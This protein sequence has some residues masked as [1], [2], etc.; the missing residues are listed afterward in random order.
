LSRLCD[1]LPVLSAGFHDL[2][3]ERLDQSFADHPPIGFIYV[4]CQFSLHTVVDRQVKH[5]ADDES[6]DAWPIQH[7]SRP[8]FL[9]HDL[10]LLLERHAT[11]LLPVGANAQSICR[12]AASGIPR[13]DVVDQPSCQYLICA[14]LAHK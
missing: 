11:C 4:C 12:R 6:S 7:E 13:P 3:D 10:F 5:G 1:S 9:D 14:E 8:S 2:V